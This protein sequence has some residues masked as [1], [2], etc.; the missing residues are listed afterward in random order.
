MKL[1]MYLQI[2][3]FEGNNSTGQK[4]VAKKML[5]VQYNLNSDVPI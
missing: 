4:F 1:H 5:E 2:V 3:A